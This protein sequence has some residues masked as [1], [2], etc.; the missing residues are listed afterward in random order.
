MS[1]KNI[2]STVSRYLEP[3]ISKYDYELVDVEYVNEATRW[4]LRVY[5]Y[6]DG[7]ITVN[8]CEQTSRELEEVLDE[9]LPIKQPYILEVSSPGLD[10]PLKNK[11]DYNRN[12][13]NTIDIKLYKPIYDKKEH[14]GKLVSFE[15]DIVTISTDQNK[16]IEF[17]HE[18]IALAKQA[19]IF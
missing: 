15:N 5:I 9:K 1:K 14:Q 2:E 16:T 18:D 4:Y 12:L 8:D 10:R 7:G 3:I 13:G 11:A 19:I 6:K 17:N